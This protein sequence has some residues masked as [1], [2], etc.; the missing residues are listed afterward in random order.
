AAAEKGG[1][2]LGRR[3]MAGHAQM[4]GRRG[5]TGTAA[6]RSSRF[7]H[8]S[9]LRKM[10]KFLEPETSLLRPLCPLRQSGGFVRHN[11]RSKKTKWQLALTLVWL[12]PHQRH[13]SGLPI[14][15]R[16]LISLCDAA[17]RCIRR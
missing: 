17:L 16:F 13:Y 2:L 11:E 9:T 6:Q 8:F 7:M 15:Y 1:M 3:R 10:H 14:H 12:M 5:T 4:D